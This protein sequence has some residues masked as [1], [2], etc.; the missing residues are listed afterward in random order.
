MTFELGVYSFGSTPRMVDGSHGPTAQAILQLDVG[1]MPQA[2]FLH[3]IE[4]L[5]TDVLP[6]I[7]EALSDGCIRRRRAAAERR[8]RQTQACGTAA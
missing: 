5:G 8:D 7:R 4:L 1:G 2:E 3:G 6:R